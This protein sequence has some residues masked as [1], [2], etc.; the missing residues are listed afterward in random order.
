MFLPSFFFFWVVFFYGTSEAAWLFKLFTYFTLF[1][2]AETTF[3]GGALGIFVF[4][5]I[6]PIART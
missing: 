3:F 4:P 2:P 5:G 1:V 6:A